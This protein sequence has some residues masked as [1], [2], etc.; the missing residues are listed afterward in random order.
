MC[1]DK[2]G[3][4]NKGYRNNKMRGQIIS[5][6]NFRGKGRILNVLRRFFPLGLGDYAAKVRNYPEDKALFRLN[7]QWAAE[8]NLLFFG[9][10]KS[11]RDDLIFIKSQGPYDG[12]I[13]DAG[14]N[15]GLYSVYFYF[16][17]SSGFK[18]FAF[19]PVQSVAMRCAGNI[20]I[21]RAT[22]R[23]QLET[24]ALHDKTGIAD[25]K[26][27]KDV[28]NQPGS[29]SMV[30]ELSDAVMAS[31]PAVTLDDYCKSLGKIALIKVDVE[32]NEENILR[33][34]IET[35]K[36]Y[37]PKI[38]FEVVEQTYGDFGRAHS[39]FSG[40]LI[41]LGYKL[42]FVD[43]IKKI[44]IEEASILNGNWWAEEDK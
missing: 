10:P 27:T 18:V 5:L 16:L 23:I 39:V 7:H 26:I 42:Y 21:N 19:E 8:S 37:K 17:L 31:V 11:I 15:I 9:C 34:G 20:E 22:Q 36:K 25:I 35:I 6:I 28:H 41:P 1:Y 40:L 4:A 13:I 33:G 14:A 43:G 44:P 3:E 29:S 32:G 30:W 12:H 2:V 38:F 24:K